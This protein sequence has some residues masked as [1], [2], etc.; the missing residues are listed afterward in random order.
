MNASTLLAR[1]MLHF[2]KVWSTIRGQ[3][4]RAASTCSSANIVSVIW[5]IPTGTD[6]CWLAGHQYR[7]GTVSTHRR[8]IKDLTP[9]PEDNSLYEHLSVD[10]YFSFYYH[11]SL[12]THHIHNSFIFP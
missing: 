10:F 6:Y 1:N 3:W 9:C 2:G 11:V 7:W 4:N 8:K 12:Q 5:L